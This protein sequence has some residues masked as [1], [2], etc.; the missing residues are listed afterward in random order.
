MTAVLLEEIKRV[1]SLDDD[2]LGDGERK[3]SK[4]DTKGGADDA[5]GADVSL[6][7]PACLR[8]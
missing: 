2:D 4:G 5:G 8:E 3:E 7:R 1:A 6:L